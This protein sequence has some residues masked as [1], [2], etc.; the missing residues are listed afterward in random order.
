M[1]GGEDENEERRND[2]RKEKEKRSQDKHGDH[3]AI[4]VVSHA[5]IHAVIH[6]ATTL[7]LR[8]RACTSGLFANVFFT[9]SDR[10]FTCARYLLVC[11]CVCVYVCVCVCVPAA[12]DRLVK[13]KGSRRAGDAALPR[14]S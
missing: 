12:A 11:L 14:E 6:A 2:K 1:R 3:G 4:Q 5:V 8:R 9:P 7:V 10:L 13:S